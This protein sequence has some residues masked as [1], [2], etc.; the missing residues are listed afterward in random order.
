MLFLFCLDFVWEDV[1]TQTNQ[2]GALEKAEEITFKSKRFELNIAFAVWGPDGDQPLGERS[3]GAQ[4]LVRFGPSDRCQ[5][6]HGAVRC[7]PEK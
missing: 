7:G 3:D 6:R 2:L 5:A 4:L 1:K